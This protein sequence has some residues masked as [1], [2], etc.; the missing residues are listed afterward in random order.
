MTRRIFKYLLTPETGQLAEVLMPRGA[1]PLCVAAQGPHVFV[2]AMLPD[3]VA[4][5]RA[6]RFR[7]VGTGSPM[8]ELVGTYL[9]TAH[10]SDGVA[11]HVF[12]E[13]LRAR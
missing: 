9:G 6:M 7:I 11:W 2:W 4:P 10:T 12:E 5:M 3:D 1:E 8:P 13:G